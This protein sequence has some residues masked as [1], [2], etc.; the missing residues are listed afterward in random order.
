[1]VSLCND[2]SSSQTCLQVG[3]SMDSCSSTSTHFDPHAC[4]GAH[5]QVG[6]KIDTIMLHIL[7]Q[8]RMQIHK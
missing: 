4:V 2:E 7:V 6:P 8:V 1:M 3:T 5:S